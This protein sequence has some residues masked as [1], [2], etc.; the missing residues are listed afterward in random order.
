MNELKINAIANTN[1]SSSNNNKP[2]KHDWWMGLGPVCTCLRN[3]PNHSLLSLRPSPSCL[4]QIIDQIFMQTQRRNEC[5]SR[6]LQGGE[7]GRNWGCITGSIWHVVVAAP[8]WRLRRV[9]NIRQA[10]PDRPEWATGRMNVHVQNLYLDIC[11]DFSR[12]AAADK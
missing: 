8:A 4:I 6:Q 5:K 3:P 7:G 11:N 9:H 2:G 10:L 1:S 12:W